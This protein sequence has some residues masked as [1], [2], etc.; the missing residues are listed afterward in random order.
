MP[1]QISELVVRRLAVSAFMPVPPS[2]ASGRGTASPLTT[3]SATPPRTTAL[4]LGFAAELPFAGDRLAVQL[5]VEDNVTW[6]DERRWRTC[7]GS[8]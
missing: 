2:C 7:R 6:W 4:N 1:Q 3:R 8:T 5:A